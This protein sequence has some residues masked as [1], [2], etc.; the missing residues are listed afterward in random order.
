MNYLNKALYAAG[1][2][3]FSAY[4]RASVKR[5]ID[6]I[7]RANPD[8]IISSEIV[9]RGIGGAYTVVKSSRPS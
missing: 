1:L 2:F 7:K 6:E 8:A 9:N 3:A 4:H 5:E